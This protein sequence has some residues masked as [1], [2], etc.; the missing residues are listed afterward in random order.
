MKGIEKLDLNVNDEE[1]LALAQFVKRLSWS[2]LRSCAVSDDEAW[3]IK[4][5]IDKLQNALREEG[6]SPR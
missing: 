4:H 2:D 3:L 5:A 6:Y 1:A